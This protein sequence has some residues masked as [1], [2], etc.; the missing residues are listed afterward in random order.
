[1]SSDIWRNGGMVPFILQLGIRWRWVA[2]YLN[3]PLYSWGKNPRYPVDKRIS[4]LH[5]R[6]EGCGNVIFYTFWDSNIHSSVVQSVACIA[7]MSFHT[8]HV[9]WKQPSV[10]TRT[11]FQYRQITLIF[12][13]P[14]GQ[15]L[16]KLQF[17]PLYV[18]GYHAHSLVSLP[19][20]YRQTEYW[21]PYFL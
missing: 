2:S 8:W 16:R 20:Y 11:T 17:I 21:V 10:C 1:M 5:S 13:G 9:K 18:D 19:R 15:T 14:E 4:R 12:M 6:S 3:R 7:W